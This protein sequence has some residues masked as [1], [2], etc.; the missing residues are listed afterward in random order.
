MRGRSEKTWSS[1][2][3]VFSGGFEGEERGFEIVGPSLQNWRL[4]P[5]SGLE[6]R[7]ILPAWRIVVVK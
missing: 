3:N 6:R 5:A 2:G 4:D 7:V 1:F